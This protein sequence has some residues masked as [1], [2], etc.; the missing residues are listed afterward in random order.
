MELKG[1][2]AAELIKALK[3]HDEA[4][5]S[6]LRLL[7]AAFNNMEIEKRTAGVTQMEDKDYQAVVKKEAKKRQESIEL[8]KAAGRAELQQ[9]EEA[10]LELLS[11]YL[12]AEMGEAEVRAVVEAV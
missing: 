2:I 10:E 3:A 7:T 11:K 6:T 8:Y 4:R 12:P 1:Q 5:V 9:K